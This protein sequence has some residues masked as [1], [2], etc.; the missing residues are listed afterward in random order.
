MILKLDSEQ[1]TDADVEIGYLHQAFEKMA[2]M[3]RD[4]VSGV[5]DPYVSGIT[6]QQSESSHQTN[7][8]MKTLTIMATIF[9]PLTVITVL[10]SFSSNTNAGFDN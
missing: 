2:E 4:I 5:L 7:Q 1:V 3:Y 8:V 9:L 6:H 10:S